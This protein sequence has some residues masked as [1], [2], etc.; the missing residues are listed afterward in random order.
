MGIIWVRL[1]ILN[2]L[3]NARLCGIICQLLDDVIIDRWYEHLA[4][5]E[6]YTKLY[7][8]GHPYISIEHA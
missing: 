2:Y 8:V 4:C 1:I 6:N 7:V 3:Y 5:Q